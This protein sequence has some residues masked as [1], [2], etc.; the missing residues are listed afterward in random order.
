MSL[1]PKKY[2]WGIRM[3]ASERYL[4]SFEVRCFPTHN[5]PHL[6]ELVA[7][8][9]MAM[10]GSIRFP[11]ADTAKFLIVRNRKVFETESGASVEERLGKWVAAGQFPLGIGGGPLDDHGQGTKRTLGVCALVYDWLGLDLPGISRLI[12]MVSGQDAGTTAKF[13]YLTLSTAIDQMWTACENDPE[14]VYQWVATVLEAYL[15]K[16]TPESPLSVKDAQMVIK[17]AFGEP[18]AKKWRTIMDRCQRNHFSAESDVRQTLARGGDDV[19]VVEVAWPGMDTPVRICLMKSDL[20][21]SARVARKETGASIRVVWRSSDN[22]A[23]IANPGF[24]L[25]PLAKKVMLAEE[26]R[27]TFQF[28]NQL[29]NGS[30]SDPDVPATSIGLGKML[31]MIVEALGL[32]IISPYAK[33]VVKA[34]NDK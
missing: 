32:K 28:G 14:F 16:G 24:D 5:C 8:W 3:K 6:D 7:R 4:S 2:Q 21:Q 33:I 23:V 20:W 29:L 34:T 22:M 15:L 12:A 10:F 30:R 17:K 31:D 19:R 11:G 13:D 27:W 9:L 18:Q 26:G 1:E 25:E